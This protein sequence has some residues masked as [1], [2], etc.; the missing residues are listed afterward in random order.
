MI[1]DS[2]LAYGIGELVSVVFLALLLSSSV[3]IK[4]YSAQQRWFNASLLSQVIY[5]TGDSINIPF[6]HRISWTSSFWPRLMN[7]Y[8]SVGMNAL[9]FT[10][11]MFIAA[12]MELPLVNN[13]NK[14]RLVSL[15]AVALSVFNVLAALFAPQNIFTT[16]GAQNLTGFYSV[17]FISM[18]ALYSGTAFILTFSQAYINR[19]NR[20]GHYYLTEQMHRCQGQEDPISADFTYEDTIYKVRMRWL[21]KKERDAFIFTLEQGE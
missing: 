1:T 9:S 6:L 14:V 12:K 15:P 11:F 13:K 17:V 3:K 10:A 7:S 8:L 18:P 2:E 16:T 5:L 21:A 20:I 19:H 4:H